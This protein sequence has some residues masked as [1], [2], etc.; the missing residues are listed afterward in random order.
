MI[1]KIRKGDRTGGMEGRGSESFFR[2]SMSLE[3]SRNREGR[4]LNSK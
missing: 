1:R 3:N 4:E 2:L